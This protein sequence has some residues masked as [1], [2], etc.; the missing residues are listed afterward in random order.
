[1]LLA[2]LLRPPR[3]GLDL[4]LQAAQAV[5][6]GGQLAGQAGAGVPP[7]RA[8]RDADVAVGVAVL[9]PPPPRPCLPPPAP[10][11]PRPRPPPSRPS[12]HLTVPPAARANGPGAGRRVRQ[13]WAHTRAGS[14]QARHTASAAR[15]PRG[16]GRPP[17]P[18]RPPSPRR[19]PGRPGAR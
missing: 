13:G 10:A 4:P 16:R 3:A 11:P 18:R 6:R 15:S 1:L 8:A 19:P 14:R 2:A 7:H 9:A 5:G 12:P 17:P